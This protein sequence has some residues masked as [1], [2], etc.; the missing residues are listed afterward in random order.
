VVAP[1]SVVQKV[2]AA[3][4]TEAPGAFVVST[5]SSADEAR[6]AVRERRIVG[7]FVMGTPEPTVLVA[8]GASGPTADAVGA[9]FTAVGEALGQSPLVEDVQPFPTS[10]PRG[11]VPFFLVLGVTIS[12][13]VFQMFL[14]AQAGPLRLAGRAIS[15]VLFAALDG[16]LAALAV[17]IVLGFAGSDW[18]LAG[19]CGLLALA[20]TAAAAAFTGLFGRVGTG[21]AAFI[22]ILL[23]NASSVSV[24]GWHFLPQPF[25]GLSPVLPASAA[26]DAVRSCLYFGGTG[27][28][29]RLGALALWVVGSFFVL[30]C[31]GLRKTWIRARIDVPA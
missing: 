7:A 5:Y 10:D 24:L 23:A 14:L 15:M 29:W 31:L 3:L 11:A 8:S 2:T 25:R 28:G 18:L 30:G 21:L 4:E 19:V 12:A 22:V 20:V 27:L 26:L 16:L 13:F 17:G 9:A 6:T 1:A